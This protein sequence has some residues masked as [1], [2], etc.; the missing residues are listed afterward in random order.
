MPLIGMITGGVD[1]KSLTVSVGDATIKYGNFIQNVFDFLIVAFC[2]F[3][4]IKAVNKISKKKEEAPAP[5]APA[6]PSNE[7]KLLAEIRDL[8]KN[9]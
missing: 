3:M 2:I 1:F 7:E 9:K 6:E 5:E 4:M 8:L